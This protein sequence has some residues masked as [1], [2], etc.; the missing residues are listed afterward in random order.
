MLELS[1]KLG[2]KTANVSI[3]ELT[4]DALKAA[5]KAAFA[6]DTNAEL[7]VLAKGKVLGSDAQ[8]TALPPNAKLM[9]MASKAADVAAVDEAPRERMRGFEED[10]VRQRTGGLGKAA[11]GA[12]AAY[13]SRT[14]GPTYKFH[15]L[16][17]LSPLP[18]GVTPGVAAAE[19]RLREL[20][21]DP[22]ILGVMKKH[23]FI[24]GKLS[25]MPPQGQVGVSEMCV[26]GLNRN[27][28]QEILLRLRTDDGGGLRPYASVVPVLLHELTHNVWSEHDNNFKQ[29]NSQLNREYKELCEPGY[30]A[31][32]SDASAGSGAAAEDHGRVLGGSGASMAEARAKAFGFAVSTPLYATPAPHFGLEDDAAAADGVEAMD[33]SAGDDGGEAASASAASSIC[34]IFGIVH[35]TAVPKECVRCGEVKEG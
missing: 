2:P 31:T 15:A 9:V 8:V 27:A 30:P 26:M 34:D 22:G 7:K 12:A 18:P 16:Q 19:Q 3:D 5:V 23:K 29:L 25:E 35:V 13:K 1:C 21:E 4:V 11:S 10:D 33:V 14:S 20:S 28:G 32:R 24:V 6:L 17:A